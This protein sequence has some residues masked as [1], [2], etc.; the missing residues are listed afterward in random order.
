MSA[1]R[2]EGG[3]LRLSPESIDALATRLAELLGGARV[4]APPM[5]SPKKMLSAAE[6]SRRWSISRRWVYDHADELGAR[7]MGTGPRP[8]LR[9]D[10]D[11]VA[12]RIGAPRCLVSPGD[13]LRLPPIAGIPHSDSL[14]GG[15]RA[16]V[17]ESKT[18]AAGGRANA[19]GPAPKE[20]LRR[21]SQPRP[22]GFAPSPL[23]RR[24]REEMI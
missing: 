20:M 3:E 17:G 18:D 6:V 9:F 7:R 23:S 16:N 13:Q 19:P 12:A 1:P 24:K 2:Q 8:R 21:D 14:S 15:T 4:P 11:E 5:E 10:P 22:A